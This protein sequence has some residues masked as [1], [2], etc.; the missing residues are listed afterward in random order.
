MPKRTGGRPS[1]EHAFFMRRCAR[2]LASRDKRPWFDVRFAP[3]V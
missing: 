1:F 2:G 3:T